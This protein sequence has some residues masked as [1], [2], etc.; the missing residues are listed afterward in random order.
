MANCKIVPTSSTYSFYIFVIHPIIFYC[1]GVTDINTNV[2][3][4]TVVVTHSDAVS[5]ESMLEKLQKVNIVGFVS[6]IS[7]S[8]WAHPKPNGCF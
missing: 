3:A 6:S 4:K 7:Y 2:E 1:V 8:M 5:K